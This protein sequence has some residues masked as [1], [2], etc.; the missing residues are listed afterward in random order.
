MTW[1]YEDQEAGYLLSTLIDPRLSYLLVNARQGLKQAFTR[2]QWK[3]ILGVMIKLK[4]DVV[5]GVYAD[6][7]ISKPLTKHDRG[8]LSHAEQVCRQI[9]IEAGAVPDSI[10]TSTRPRKSPVRR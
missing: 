9:L 1:S 10:F 2:P 5:G 6:G 3:N 8:R 7:K 4:D